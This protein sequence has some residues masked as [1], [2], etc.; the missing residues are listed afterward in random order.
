MNNYIIIEEK[1]KNKTIINIIDEESDEYYKENKY[2]IILLKTIFTNI[3]GYN[4]DYIKN[5]G[6]YYKTWSN[7]NSILQKGYVITPK[8]KI[9]KVKNNIFNDFTM[10]YMP[11][12]KLISVI[13]QPYNIDLILKNCKLYN[14]EFE[15]GTNWF[16][17]K[18]IKEYN[19]I[20]QLI[21]ENRIE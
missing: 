8:N 7:N 9:Y 11:N 4:K 19:E 6:I 21:K 18:H 16:W 2:D 1:I 20:K 15:L 12:Y 17:K 13:E 14:Y 10:E 5:N 3:A